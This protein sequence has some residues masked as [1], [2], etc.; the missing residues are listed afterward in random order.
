MTDGGVRP[1]ET[2]E[3][4]SLLRDR[5]FVR[6]WSVGAFVMAMRWFEILATSVFT[7]SVTQSAL[8]VA[9]VNLAR[10]APNLLF[11]AFTGAIADRFDRRALLLGGEIV[12]VLIT[13]F[14]CLLAIF[15][16]ITPWHIA[17]GAFINGIV[18][19]MEFPVRRNMMG[20]IAGVDRI[21]RAMGLDLTANNATRIVGPALGGF[22]L[23]AIGITGIFAVA[24]ACYAACAVLVFG[25]VAPPRALAASAYGIFAYIVEGLRYVR[26]N[27]PLVGLMAITVILNVWGLPYVAM[28]PV[29][30]GEELGLTAFPIGLLLSSEGV[31]ALLGSLLVAGYAK[32]THFNKIYLYGSFLM[33]AA[34]VLF[35]QSNHYGFSLLVTFAAGMGIAGFTTMQAT[36]PY[37][38]SEPAMRA[39]VMGVLAVCI[40]SGP[41]GM[42]HVGFL[43]NWLG[44]PMALTVMGIEGLLALAATMWI[45]R[46]VR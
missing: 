9:L 11:G 42:L 23:E 5:S 22:V 16:V 18:F 28:V 2:P 38:L 21:S 4:R 25:V 45:W 27:R 39:R 7:Y 46:E 35:A 36:L 24:T 3:I 30:G 14:L 8:A 44:A 32:P 13:G 29:I 15:G 37:V 40:G 19:S 26:A 20:D 10:A 34:V 17:I 1:S 31:G 6:L 33:I 43:A 41:I 12:L